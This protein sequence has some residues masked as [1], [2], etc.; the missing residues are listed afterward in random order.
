M[1]MVYGM[2]QSAFPRPIRVVICDLSA[3]IIIAAKNLLI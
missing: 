1:D 2:Y 3:E